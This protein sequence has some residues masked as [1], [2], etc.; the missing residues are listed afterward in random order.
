MYALDTNTLIYF[1]KAAGRVGDRLLSVPPSEVSIPSVVLYELEVGIMESQQPARRRL[2]LEALLATITVLPFDRNAAA[3]AAE[4]GAGLR[5]VGASIGPMDTLI[6]GTALAH[7]AT[8][9]T[10]NLAEFRR[11]RGLNVVDWF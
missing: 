6:A 3:R 4:L 7:G 5:K 10:H 9:V 8:L 2:Q 11:V 1:F